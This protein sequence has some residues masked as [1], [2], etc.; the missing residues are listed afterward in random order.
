MFNVFIGS[1]KSAKNKKQPYL[2]GLKGVYGG[3][4]N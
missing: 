4:K 1:K 3:A 2:E